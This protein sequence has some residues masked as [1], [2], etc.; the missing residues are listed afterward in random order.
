M[1]TAIGRKIKIYELDDEGIYLIFP[2]EEI[3]KERTGI[4]IN[5]ESGE[6]THGII[7]TSKLDRLDGILKGK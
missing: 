2:S 4:S 5:M 1:V 3:T 6:I 7:R